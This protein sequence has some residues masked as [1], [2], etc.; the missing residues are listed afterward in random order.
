MKIHVDG[1]EDISNRDIKWRCEEHDLGTTSID[2]KI[3]YRDIA[4]RE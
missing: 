4:F 1:V 3:M 2:S